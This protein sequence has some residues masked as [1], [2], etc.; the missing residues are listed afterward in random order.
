VDDGYLTAWRYDDDG[1]LR[2]IDTPQLR[3]LDRE[4]TVLLLTH[5]GE[6]EAYAFYEFVESDE[7]RARSVDFAKEFVAE[8]TKDLQFRPIVPNDIPPNFDPL[9]DALVYPEY[10]TVTFRYYEELD[11]QL[12]IDETTQELGEDEVEFDKESTGADTIAGVH[13]NVRERQLTN[14]WA[15]LSMTWKVSSVSYRLSYHRTVA[16]DEQAAEVASEYVENSNDHGVLE[17]DGRP[18]VV[19]SEMR[20]I[21]RKMV[22]SIIKQ[23]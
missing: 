2:P 11:D 4:E 18:P 16:S 3:K 15:E 21:S 19:D 23:A 20:E 22:A 13:V 6:R 14:A 17:S 9:P 5:E 1:K 10:D 8:T 7:G 12:F